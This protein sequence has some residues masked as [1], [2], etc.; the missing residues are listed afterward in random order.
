MVSTS[1]LQQKIKKNIVIDYYSTI[2]STNTEIKRRVRAGDERP[3]L[4]IASEQ[5]QGRGRQ[6][7]SFYSPANTGIYMSLMLPVRGALSDVVSVTGRTAVAVA[8]G[9]DS[10]CDISCGIKWVNDIYWNNQKVCGILVEAVTGTH[11]SDLVLV[12]GIGINLTTETF[13]TDVPNAGS[14]QFDGDINDLLAEIINR[15]YEY[16]DNMNH[17]DYL[18]KYRAKSIVLGKPIMFIENDI[19]Y[20]GTAADIDHQG[21]LEVILNSGERKILRSGEITLRVQG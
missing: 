20:Y 7:K 16:T 4:I 5:T 8:E 3:C 1:F 2:D 10:I 15:I 14:I 21:G 6:G 11:E 19:V 9:I 13:P 12:I 18:S 17:T